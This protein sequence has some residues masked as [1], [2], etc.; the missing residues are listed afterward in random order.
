MQS[1]S[2]KDSEESSSS[3]V[4]TPTTAEKKLQLESRRALALS[5]Y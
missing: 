2:R 3:T 1:K 4:D 5:Y